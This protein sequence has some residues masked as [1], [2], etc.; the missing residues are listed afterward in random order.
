MRENRLYGCAS[1]RAGISRK[2]PP[3]KNQNPLIW[4]PGWRETKNLKPIDNVSPGEAT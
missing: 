3:G 2:A 4:K 1:A